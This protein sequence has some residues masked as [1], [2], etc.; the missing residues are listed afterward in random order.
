METCQG[1]VV[2][3]AIFGRYLLKCIKSCVPLLELLTCQFHSWAGAFDLISQPKNV[4]EYTKKNACFYM[5]LDEQTESYF[6]NISA[7][8]DNN[9]RSGLWRIVVVR[10]LPY[11]DPRR[12]GKVNLIFPYL[13]QVVRFLSVTKFCKVENFKFLVLM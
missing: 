5:F 6:K 9:K 10:N 1:L 4:S 8:E 7:L 12:N 2:A 13:L 11:T 3:S